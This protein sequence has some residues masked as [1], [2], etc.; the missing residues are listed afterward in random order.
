MLQVHETIISRQNQYSLKHH[1]IPHEAHKKHHFC[2]TTRGITDNSLTWGLQLVIL[3]RHDNFNT[4]IQDTY[5]NVCDY[6]IRT[7]G[8]LFLQQLRLFE[9]I[10]CVQQ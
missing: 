4:Y 7:K 9:A 10:L 5:T 8:L 3:F 6:G 1:K 2:S